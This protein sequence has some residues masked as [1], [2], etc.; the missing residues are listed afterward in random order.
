MLYLLGDA[1]LVGQV[2][3]ALL[4]GELS[5]DRVLDLFGQIGHHV[6]LDTAQYKRR[7]ECLQASGAVALGMLDRAF[8]SLCKRFTRAQQARHQKVEDAP[9]LG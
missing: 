1:V 3:L 8:E 2:E 5:H 4:A 9:E 7:H 6:L